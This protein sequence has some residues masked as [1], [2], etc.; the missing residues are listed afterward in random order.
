MNGV[1][2]G[3]DKEDDINQDKE[4]ENKDEYENEECNICSKC[5]CNKRRWVRI[6]RVL[7]KLIFSCL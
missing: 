4:D 1:L 5:R 7:A 2:N 3:K 6:E